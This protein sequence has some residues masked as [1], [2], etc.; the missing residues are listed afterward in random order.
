MPGYLIDRIMITL[1]FLLLSGCGTIIKD[2][3][4]KPAHQQ[5]WN[6][7]VMH[8][9]YPL[10]AVMALETENIKL[11]NQNPSDIWAYCKRY[12]KLSAS[13]RLQF[14]GDLLSAISFHESRHNPA[15]KYQERFKDNTGSRVISRG[16]L[17]LSFES[18]KGYG[19]PL[20]KAEQL[21]N[22]ANNI[23]CGVRIL[24]HW[25]LE[26]GVIS[27][28]V[29][30]LQSQWRGGARYWNV[31]RQ[32]EKRAAIQAQIQQQSYCHNEFY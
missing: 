2:L 29:G 24:N 11:V 12:S 5:H 17:Q 16:L 1:S 18:A 26:D 30:W 27:D 7:T 6:W 13:Q 23:D 19:C 8:K 20:E 28:E 32:P 9:H 14:W 22:P 10:F 4:A 3:P 25:V 31:L 15:L 21:H